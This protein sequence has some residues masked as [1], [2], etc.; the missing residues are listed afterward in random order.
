MR[1]E[2]RKRGITG[3]KAVW[4]SEDPLSPLEKPEQPDAGD[5]SVP[6]RD[7]PGSFAFVPAAAGL[8][9][10]SRVVLDLLDSAH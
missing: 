7:T 9:L 4:S 3:L 6:R 1:K 8:L 2:C 5:S 10:A